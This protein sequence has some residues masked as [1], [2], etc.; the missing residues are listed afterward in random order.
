MDAFPSWRMM[1]R[2]SE[3]PM[4]RRRSPF[5]PVNTS[6]FM[7]FSSLNNSVGLYFRLRCD[8]KVSATIWKIDTFVS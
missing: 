3:P 8:T 6:G 1:T 7:A 2:A 5:D 4:K